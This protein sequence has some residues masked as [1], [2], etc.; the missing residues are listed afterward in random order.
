MRIGIFAYNFNHKKT[1][2]G[3]I[4]LWLEGY[5]ISCIFAQD[6]LK[7]NFYQSKI[8]V[9]PKD[10]YYIHPSRIAERLN[11]PYHVLMHNSKECENLIKEYELDLGIILG[12]RILKKH[13]IDAFRI[14][15]INMHPGLLPWNRGLD[16]LKWAIIDELPQGVT[17]HLID[18]QVD[19]GS[20]LLQEIIEVYPDDTLLDIYLRLQS[21]ELD[22]MIE[23]IKKLET[24]FHPTRTAIEGKYNRAVP[25]DIEKDLLN[26]FEKYKQ[27]YE[28]I[29]SRF[30]K[31]RS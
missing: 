6:R 13:I 1:F 28:L 12:A 22:L 19:W 31:L 30:L 23:S 2:E 3:I 4:R 25:P 18:A 5:K 7:L 17:T 14:G 10:I 8:R 11:I 20:I 9:G 15:I 24:G 27:N 16:N 21:K 29:K 26:L